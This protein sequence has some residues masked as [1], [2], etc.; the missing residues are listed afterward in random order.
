[1]QVFENDKTAYFDV[2]DTLVQWGHSTD[3]RALEFD[4]YGFKEKL[5]PHESHIMFLKRQ[6]NR[7]FTIIVWS[8]GGAVWAK[9][10]IDKLGIAD[11]VDL[12]LTKPF[13][14]VDDKDSTHF[15]TNRVF[16]NNFKPHA[17][18]MQEIDESI[19]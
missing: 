2:D 16:F 15:M 11:Y 4:S 10:V 19:D 6:K 1:M 9:E 7:G 8:Q 13:M 14:Y 12:V 18:H 5:V 17:L 3:P